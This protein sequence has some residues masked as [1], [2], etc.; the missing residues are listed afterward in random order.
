MVSQASFVRFWD[1]K[2]YVE[3]LTF[4]QMRYV[5][6]YRMVNGTLRTEKPWVLEIDLPDELVN[7][8]ATGSEEDVLH[9]L[10]AYNEASDAR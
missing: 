5:K 3:A 10:N 4:Q 2:G 6:P 8:L 1:H 7:A 9:I